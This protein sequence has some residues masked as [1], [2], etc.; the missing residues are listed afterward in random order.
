MVP[1]AKQR[2]G[3]AGVRAWLAKRGVNALPR[4]YDLPIEAIDEKASRSNQAREGKIV[5]EVVERYLVGLKAG[6]EFPP[7]VGY[8]PAG[9][10]KSMGQLL[11]EGAKVVLIDGNHREAT[12]KKAGRPTLPI[13]IIAAD[14]PSE[15]IHLLTVEANS[16]HGESVSA[17]WRLIQGAHLIA[18]GW[19]LEIASEAAQVSPHVLRQKMITDKAEVRAN[20]LHIKGFDQLS[21]TAKHKLSQIKEDAPFKAAALVVRDTTMNTDDSATFV[22]EIKELTSEADRMEHIAKV[23]EQ[24]LLEQQIKRTVDKGVRVSSPKH[25]LVSAVGGVLKSDP[26]EVAGAIR[27]IMEQKELS[28]RLSLLAEHVLILQIAVAEALS[29]GS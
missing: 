23:G 28:D 15:L 7:S 25:K 14:T 12:Y 27:T 19:T 5:E 2:E 21:G 3:E 24:R 18:Q 29:D 6:D 8:F 22:R 16:R 26:D 20:A 4:V 10:T 9:G 17:R 1:S 13:I 11:R